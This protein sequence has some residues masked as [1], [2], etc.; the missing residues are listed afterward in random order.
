MMDKYLT[1]DLDVFPCEGVRMWPFPQT[2]IVVNESE[3]SGTNMH[4][5]RAIML[6]EPERVAHLM[7]KFMPDPTI[8]IYPLEN[9][10]PIGATLYRLNPSTLYLHF[11]R[12]RKIRPDDSTQEWIYTYPVMRGVCLWAQSIGVSRIETLGI[13][14][15]QDYVVNLEEPFTSLKETEW[16]TLNHK[17][18]YK[19]DEEFLLTPVEYILPYLW[20]IITGNE[21]L[22]VVV[23]SDGVSER[24]EEAT[25][26]LGQYLL[27]HH[28]IKLNLEHLSQ[29]IDEH[30]EETR[31]V[32]E[33]FI[34]KADNPSSNGV[35]FG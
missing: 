14:S 10:D 7:S 32:S 26:T 22:S 15:L 29:W 35:M 19:S 33:G 4:L 11:P 12:W 16:R 13:L 24:H 20:R 3:P 9:S 28:K 1:P 18:P 21:G 27:S 6:R 8:N 17:V 31:S 5:H 25:K 2:L 23:G 30:E 34:T